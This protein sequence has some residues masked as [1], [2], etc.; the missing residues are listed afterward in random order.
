MWHL[1]DYKHA[2]IENK[3]EFSYNNFWANCAL[4]PIEKSL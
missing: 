4:H 2:W 1:D 3:C